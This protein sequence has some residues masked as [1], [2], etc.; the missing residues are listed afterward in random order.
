MVLPEVEK[1]RS[2]A[3]DVAGIASARPTRREN[4]KIFSPR[5]HGVLQLHDERVLGQPFLHLVGWP[6]Q[7]VA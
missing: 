2:G 7:L 6:S 5:R 3:V 1:R 4:G